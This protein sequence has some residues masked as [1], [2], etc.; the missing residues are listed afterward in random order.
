MANSEGVL[1]QLGHPSGLT[2]RLLL[3]W[4]NFVN[5]GM[6][7]VTLGALNLEDGDRVLE[8]G[9]GGGALIR[10]I[11]GGER[12]VRVTGTDISRLAI[13][14]AERRFRRAV[15]AG[16]ADFKEC[17]TS[18][19]LFGDAEFSKACCVNVIYFWPDAAAMIGEVFRVLAPGGRFVLC[20]AEGAPDGVTRFSAG[21]VED[22]LADAGFETPA[23]THGAD[24]E[25]GTYHCTVAVKPAGAASAE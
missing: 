15:A 21:E 3:R 25:N 8:I 20:Y 4:L 17:G 22:L 23:T 10:A 19:L 16:L 13:E 9:F 2:G 12:K 7:G 18:A 1:R 11:L 24:R 5:R 6:N 14:R